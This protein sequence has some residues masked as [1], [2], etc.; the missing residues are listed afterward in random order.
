MLL[1]MWIN[2]PFFLASCR[3]PKSLAV[4]FRKVLSH[5]LDR[6]RILSILFHTSL[7][8]SSSIL[9]S[10]DAWLS[11]SLVIV[12]F[13]FSGFK[14]MDDNDLHWDI[15]S[16]RFSLGM[17]HWGTVGSAMLMLEIYLLIMTTLYI[18]LLLLCT[19]SSLNRCSLYMQLSFMSVAAMTLYIYISSLIS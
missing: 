6:L 4:D 11:L 8:Y 2:S 15:P 13:V 12:P 16:R 7:N 5:I 19:L 3:F 14:L 9:I 1:Y 17:V 10:K 18:N